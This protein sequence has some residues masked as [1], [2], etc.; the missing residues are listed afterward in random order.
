MMESDKLKEIC[1]HFEIDTKIEPYGNGNI[2]D[3]YLCESA[4]RFILQK[5]NEN[6]F[7]EP[8]KV[9]EISSI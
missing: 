8:E 5:I 4:P 9:M 7:K 6:I 2:N 1:L 3:T